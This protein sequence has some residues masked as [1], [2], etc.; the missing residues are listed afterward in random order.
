M[1]FYFFTTEFHTV[2]QSV[3]DIYPGSHGVLCKVALPRF[4]GA[5]ESLLFIAD[6][7]SAMVI[8][9]QEGSWNLSLL[10]TGCLS[11]PGLNYRERSFQITYYRHHILIREGML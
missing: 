6:Y 1:C 10:P 5:A 4:F 9:L 3:V 2:T 8:G 11:R 7:G